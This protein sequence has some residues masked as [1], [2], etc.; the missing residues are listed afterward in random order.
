[1]PRPIF[2]ASFLLI[3][4]CLPAQESAKPTL[5][6]IVGVSHDDPLAKPV[7]GSSTSGY[8][9]KDGRTKLT[10]AELGRFI[11]SS[12]RDGYTLTLYP[13][14]KNGIFADMRCPSAKK[15]IS[16]QHP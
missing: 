14:S 6:D 9:E 4:L 13:E 5:A 1:M 16:P 8:V 7:C 3:S 11:R 12:L 10:E 2:I 15:A